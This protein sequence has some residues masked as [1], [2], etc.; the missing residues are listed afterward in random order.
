MASP[1]EPD[2]SCSTYLKTVLH[3]EFRAT[4]PDLLSHPAPHYVMFTSGYTEGTEVPW[5]PDCAV[6]LPII[7]WVGA[8]PRMTVH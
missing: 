5:C 4:L 7:R 2:S 6:T 8:P 3:G 1:G